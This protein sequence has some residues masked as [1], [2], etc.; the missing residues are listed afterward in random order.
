[1]SVLPCSRSVFGDAEHSQHCT[2]TLV[3]LGRLLF[4]FL[5]L[6]F[7]HCYYC[8]LVAALSLS[9]FFFLSLLVFSL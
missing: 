1:M 6:L 4:F 9:L 2:Q 3:L 8:C 5:L 7:W